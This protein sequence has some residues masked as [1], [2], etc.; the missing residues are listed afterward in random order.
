MAGRS[1]RS[2]KNEDDVV[3]ILL[4]ENYDSDAIFDSSLKALTAIEKMVGPKK[5]KELF[6]D[7]VVTLPGNPQLAPEDDAR[8][9]VG[10]LRL[11][12]TMMKMI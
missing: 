5:F 12:S 9:A 8:P 4:G 3:D 7:Q 11:T 6:A 2:F 10:L 1:K